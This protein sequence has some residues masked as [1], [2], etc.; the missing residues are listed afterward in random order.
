MLAK[1]AEIVNTKLPK[2][3]GAN[4]GNYWTNFIL[5]EALLR[6]ATALIQGQPTT[7]E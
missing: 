3:A 1:G 2:L 6:E 7:K 4:M 5:A